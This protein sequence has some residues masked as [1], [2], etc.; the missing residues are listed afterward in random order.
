[1]EWLGFSMRLIRLLT[2]LLSAVAAAAGLGDYCH[3]WE[4]GTNGNL[5]SP[6]KCLSCHSNTF[7]LNGTCVKA[8]PINYIEQN[9][10]SPKR[11]YRLA[12]GSVCRKAF[13]SRIQ[14]DGDASHGG[15]LPASFHAYDVKA[16]YGSEDGFA[17]LYYDGAVAGFGNAAKA[18]G[19]VGDLNHVVK[20]AKRIFATGSAFAVVYGND[21]RLAAWGDA[22]NGGNVSANLTNVTDVFS[23]STAFAAVLTPQNSVSVWGN[24]REGGCWWEV[25]A[26]EGFS[27]MPPALS[28][29]ETVFSTSAAFAALL[30]TNRTV[31]VWGSKRHGGCNGGTGGTDF[32]CKPGSVSNVTTIFSNDH[33]FV[34]LLGDGTLRSWGYNLYG[35]VGI[36]ADLVGAVQIFHNEYSFVAKQS[37]GVIKAWGH[38]QNGGQV[39]DRI[40]TDGV[41][42][43]Y[44]VGVHKMYAALRS[45]GSI[46]CWGYQMS[47]YKGLIESYT[48][49]VALR[50]SGKAFSGI[51][52][53]GSVVAWPSNSFGGTAPSPTALPN[54]AA[55]HSTYG[56][57]VAL[58]TNHSV[59]SWGKFSDTFSKSGVWAVATTHSA[60]VVM[61]DVCPTG[62]FKQEVLG[63]HCE[64]CPRGSYYSANALYNCPS[65]DLGRASNELG[66]T[67]ECPICT[68]GKY[69]DEL[70][71][72]ECK[73]C[74][75]G[76]YL[77]IV[78]P[79]SPANHRSALN[80]THCPV[81]KFIPITGAPY[82]AN[83]LTCSTGRYAD[84]PGSA[85]CRRCQF[86]KY[87]ADDGSMASLHDEDSDCKTCPQG[88]YT[89][90][91]GSTGCF[92]CSPGK[93]GI[94][95]ALKNISI[96][97]TEC[98]AG[99]YSDESGAAICKQCNAGYSSGVGETDCFR[100]KAG[101]WM[102]ST[103]LPGICV[104][105]PYGKHSEIGSAACEFC[106]AG[107]FANGDTVHSS[108]PHKTS[109]GC[110]LCPPGKYSTA[111]GG[112]NESSCL[113]CPR[114]TYSTAVGATLSLCNRCPPGTFSY[115]MA[116]NDSSAC[117]SCP[118]GH[119]CVGGALSPIECSKGE[120]S[121]ARSTFCRK[122]AVGKFS[123]QNAQ[124]GCT[125]C[126]PGTFQDSNGASI[127]RRCPENTFSN[128]SGN[129][130]CVACATVIPHSVAPGVTGAVSQMA[131]TCA[132]QSGLHP[133]GF[134]RNPVGG[135][136]CLP[137]PSPGAVCK[138]PNTSVHSLA[139]DSGFWRFSEEAT[140]F[141]KCEVMAACPGGTVLDN[142][143][144]Q[145]RD[146]HIGVMCNVCKPGFA[147][148]SNGVCLLCSG[149]N[150]FREGTVVMCAAFLTLLSIYYVYYF[151]PYFHFGNE[152]M[153]QFSKSTMIVS[154][155]MKEDENGNMVPVRQASKHL[156]LAICGLFSA[157]TKPPSELQEGNG[158]TS[159]DETVKTKFRII[160]GHLQMTSMLHYTLRIKWPEPFSG[161]VKFTSVTNLNIPETFKSIFP[162]AFS[163]PFETSFYM[164][165][166]SLPALTIIIYL[167][168][169]FSRQCWRRKASADMGKNLAAVFFFW[170]FVLFPGMISS[171]FWGLKCKQVGETHLLNRDFALRCFEGKHDNIATAAV[172][173][174][175]LYG[176]GLPW[177]I[178]KLLRRLKH[179]NRL[180][181]PDSVY[182]YGSLYAAYKP[183][184]CYFE[185]IQLVKKMCF[186][187]IYVFF[188]T[189][190]LVQLVMS[191]LLFHGFLVLVLGLQP[192]KNGQD[193]R[194]LSLTTVQTIVNLLYG[195][196]VIPDSNRESVDVGL[197]GTLL[198]LMNIAV[199]LCAGYCLYIPLRQ[200]SNEF[201]SI[202]SVW[203]TFYLSIPT[204]QRKQRQRRPV[205]TPTVQHED[206]RPEETVLVEVM[207]EELEIKED[208]KADPRKT[209]PEKLSPLKQSSKYI[210]P[211]PPQETKENYDSFFFDADEIFEGLEE[212]ILD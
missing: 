1:M 125:Q 15:V 127:C 162:C 84:A 129:T 116:A 176:L 121:A 112:R 85:T 118:A 131:C 150:A 87:L 74:R 92:P 20:N 109:T 83:C 210:I 45:D 140:V 164:N 82:A 55:L 149:D 139:S 132:G 173:F 111:T 5:V 145:C 163:L 200:I 32:A 57:F 146:G 204:K 100:C 73:R 110:S 199:L 212:E 49:I 205:E 16:V 167:S 68:S 189:G 165:I 107:Q 198:L 101:E 182:A 171:T 26:T 114:G 148:A 48:N 37:D 10:R 126:A 183:D 187:G 79:H 67:G 69:S 211:S 90:T 152:T 29:V 166:L 24:S 95:Q 34:A 201:L 28:G 89:V 8:C 122:C 119:R 23:T 155:E 30:A 43:R 94:L 135:E 194:L 9:A 137:C 120:W 14:A 192:H 6:N 44:I 181:S 65:C 54:A 33:V 207:G 117:K 78:Y 178:F 147:K 209:K 72:P 115:A 18:Y 159:I 42:V 203:K 144:G 12:V 97:C 62:Y 60:I 168:M 77:E 13:R 47:Y 133:L 206:D 186:A 141:H 88:K 17:V 172:V 63:H 197:I 157:L 25:S 103:S 71:Q 142:V 41:S 195:L 180:H 208:V 27:C 19:S 36:P 11:N 158:A 52:A 51:T 177:F 190:S 59:A 81:G 106:Q 151:S 38:A 70:R 3:V 2:F 86:G 134:Y 7:L 170:A 136:A 96:G 76:F 202:W 53:S 64:A 156:K 21:S 104:P 4:T 105:C 169:A 196:F 128:T 93:R 46:V 39:E 58:T 143:D 113:P 175:F 99:F 98:N 22:A 130:Q 188:P 108:A 56:T 138:N 80:C 35:G 31:T 161:F 61:Q 184:M 102:N 123:N 50:G 75:A 185:I 154:K 40:N 174:M 193:N 179:G 124:E 153:R 66:F 91:M 191:I 160:I